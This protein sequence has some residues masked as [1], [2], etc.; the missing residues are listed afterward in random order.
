MYACSRGGLLEGLYPDVAKADWAAVVLQQDMTEGYLPVVV[1]QGLVG[2]FSEQLPFF[3]HHDAVV[4]EGHP[5]GGVGMGVLL[6]GHPVR[7]PG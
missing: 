4:D 2:G 5:L 7:R 1:G 6:V 3:V